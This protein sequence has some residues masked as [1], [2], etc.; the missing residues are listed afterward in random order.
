MDGSA[1][2]EKSEITAELLASTRSC[3]CKAH[4]DLARGS[5]N[6]FIAFF[7]YLP[8]KNA[9]RPLLIINMCKTM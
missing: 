5:A 7:K 4:M 1:F 8:V 6:N 3:I 2:H 9:A